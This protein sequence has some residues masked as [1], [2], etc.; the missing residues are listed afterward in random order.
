[1]HMISRYGRTHKVEVHTTKMFLEAIAA[2]VHC[3]N[4]QL[5]DQLVEALF[6]IL[7]Y[8]FKC[9]ELL[10]A[11]KFFSTEKSSKEAAESEDLDDEE[12]SAPINQQTKVAYESS[13]YY[14][15]YLHEKNSI[16]DDVKQLSGFL[17]PKNKYYS[18]IMARYFL[19]HLLAYLCFWTIFLTETKNHFSNASVENHFKQVKMAEV[20]NLKVGRFIDIIE[21]SLRST[22]N[23][24]GFQEPKS[25]VNVAKRQAN[26]VSKPD[27]LQSEEF[28][29]SGK[30]NRKR[31]YVPYQDATIIH[32]AAIE[33]R[34]SSL[35]FYANHTVSNDNYYFAPSSFPRYYFVSYIHEYNDDSELILLMSEDYCSL[36]GEN[37]ISNKVIDYWS[38]IV[39]SKSSFAHCIAY[40]P[41]ELN[42]YSLLQRCSRVGKAYFEKLFRRWSNKTSLILPLHVNNNHWILI[43]VDVT[44]H[45]I[46][47]MNPWPTR[48][49][50]QEENI[51]DNFKF[52][53][54]KVF[55]NLNNN[56]TVC[57]NKYP[58]QEDDFNCGVFVLFFI[59]EILKGNLYKIGKFNPMKMRERLKKPILMESLDVSDQCLC[60]GCGEIDRSPGWIEC[61]MCEKHS[62]YTCLNHYKET[63]KQMKKDSF[64]Y[65]CDLCTLWLNKN[66]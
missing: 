15:R 7:L 1:M 59:E 36:Y 35:T 13:P 53:Y 8:P 49:L 61:E 19:Q 2:L 55:P 64:K 9:L 62:H 57:K 26:R 58:K 60:C 17:A 34:R 23:E 43:Y 3:N 12:A 27:D 40:T 65:K 63:F 32:E 37:W 18:K 14:Q 56:W 31:R 4:I 5:F 22:Y 52:C 33:T 10:K 28:W 48:D 44:N 47:Y 24:L 42:F 11:L 41:C 50:S 6:V 16:E 46:Y 54:A 25:Y 66:L 30:D 45:H 51:L 20:D 38:N 29:R 39:L 21:P